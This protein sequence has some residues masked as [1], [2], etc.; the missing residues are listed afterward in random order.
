M[1]RRRSVSCQPNLHPSSVL[2][3]S[4]SVL[5][6]RDAFAPTWNVYTPIYARRNDSSKLKSSI[7]KWCS[8][9]FDRLDDFDVDEAEEILRSSLELSDAS[10]DRANFMGK[11]FISNSTV[12][13]INAKQLKGKKV[14]FSEETAERVASL[15][16]R[17]SLLATDV[18]HV[19]NKIR[20]TKA[21]QRNKRQ[22]PLMVKS[23]IVDGPV[24][25]QTIN[26]R[27]VTDLVYQ[28]NRRNLNMKSVVANEVL[29]VQ[30]LFVNGK[31]DGLELSVDNV[32]M[33]KTQTLRPLTIDDFTSSTV[34]N[35]AQ[36]NSLPFNEFFKLL[37]R[38]V[39]RKIPNMIHRLDVE[40][41]TIGRFLNNRNFTALA[42]NS[43]KTTGD[44]VITGAMNIRELKANRVMFGKSPPR[45]SNIPLSMLVNINDN[46]RVDINQDVRFTEELNVNRLFVTERINNINVKNGQLQVL[47]KRGPTAQVVT[48]EKF[49]DEVRLLSPIVLRGKIESKTLE[50]MNP[51]LTIDENLVLEG[52]Y[53]ITGPVA[54]RKFISATDDIVTSSPTLGLRNLMDNG[55]NLFTTTGTSN[56]F[57]FQKGVEVKGNL[58][59]TTLNNKPVAN[60][61]RSDFRDQQTIRGTINFKSGLAVHGGT[62]QADVVNDVDLNQLNK[63][64]LKRSSRATQFIDGNVEFVNLQVAKLVSPGVTINGK[65]IDLVLNTNEKQDVSQLQLG[66]ARVRNLKVTNMRQ[67]AGAKIFGSDLNFII[68]DTVTKDS[69]DFIADKTFTDLDVE[70]LMFA[71][72]NEW[73]S[74]IRNY[75][76]SIAQDLNITGNM[77]FT[78]DMKIGNL[79]F[80]GTINGIAYDDMVS[81]WLQVE[82]DQAFTAPQTFNSLE[83]E[84]NLELTN[85]TI[86]GVDIGTKISESVWIDQPMFVENVVFENEIVVNG[87]VLSPTVNGMTLDGKLIRNNTN[88]PQ[89]IQKLVVDGDMRVEFLN[90]T[91]LNG[92][93]CERF[94]KAFAGDDNSTSLMV[95]GSAHFIYQPKL[96]SLNNENLQELFD[97]LWMADRD[98]VLTGDDIQFLGSVRSEGIIYSDVSK[99]PK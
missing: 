4:F 82:G 50:K 62:V 84:N 89:T 46:R 36:V 20:F 19:A 67:Q 88:D 73:K 28:S 8:D 31:I 77:I 99:E 81:N 26:G 57:V 59:A 21:T 49:F 44:Q 65:S 86:N 63:T 40:T 48:G 7:T 22:A 43:L 1:E 27:A 85:G 52:D 9:A 75:E 56:A 2:I 61:V 34:S 42:I 74:T 97:N 33:N 76:D 41:M 98:A 35:I 13:N 80:S 68:D 11:V 39:D 10:S 23:L 16:R 58:R 64:V 6:N 18:R 3:G 96:V 54:I 55:I 30:E 94:V 37:R 51:I 95:H 78:K 47:R 70:H 17:L 53:S 32:L 90:F 14:S 93:E 5:S 15:S 79:E 25:I 12:G 87:K 24:N 92:I 45:I 38:K 66:S 71:D 69:L 72:G 83:I 60:F 91:Q 29:I